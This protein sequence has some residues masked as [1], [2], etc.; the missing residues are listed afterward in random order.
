VNLNE[1]QDKAMSFALPSAQNLAY[2]T[3]GLS[4]E[5]GELHSKL[6]KSIRDGLNG[7]AFAPD[8]I[9]EVGDVLWFVAGIAKQFNYTLEDVAQMNIDKLLS[10]QQRGTIQGSGDNR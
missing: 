6:A 4:G 8:C 3:Y 5:V 1:Y 10:R 7:D 2:M 9:K